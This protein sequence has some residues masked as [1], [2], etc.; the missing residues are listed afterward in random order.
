MF[1]RNEKSAACRQG[2]PKELLEKVDNLVNGL[3]RL[4]EG[5]W[6]GATFI[7]TEIPGE[8]WRSQEHDYHSQ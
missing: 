6:Y 8:G 2:N 7:D 1:E 4:Q 5:S 3:E